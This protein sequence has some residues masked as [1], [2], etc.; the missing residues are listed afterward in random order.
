MHTP[1]RSF[2]HTDKMTS[3]Q[4][5][6]EIRYVDRDLRVAVNTQERNRLRGRKADCEAALRERGVDA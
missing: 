1:T 6:Q 3:F 2:R 4:L 5:K